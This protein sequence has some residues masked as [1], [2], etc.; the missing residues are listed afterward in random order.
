MKKKIIFILLSY[1]IIDFSISNILFK[2]TNFWEYEDYVPKYW[3]ISSQI[4]HHD[5][6]PNIDVTE[7]WGGKFKKRLIDQFIFLCNSY[8]VYDCY[9]KFFIT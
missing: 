9:A 2:K 4:Y 3:R 1:L 6:M 7:Q 8:V 5:L